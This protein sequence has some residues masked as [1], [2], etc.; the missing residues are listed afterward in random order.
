MKITYECEHCK[1]YQGGLDTEE[2]CR[3]HEAVCSFNPAVRA[4]NTCR[5]YGYNLENNKWGHY[6]WIDGE[7]EWV[8]D[9][10]CLAYGDQVWRE[11]CEKW[12]PKKP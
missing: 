3:T 1:G 4:C 6:E 7:Q 5:H 9:F 8:S 10:G 2:K 12:E 11:H